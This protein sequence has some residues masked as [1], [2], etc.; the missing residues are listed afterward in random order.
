MN[1][2]TRDNR[3]EE[4]GRRTADSP[5]SGLDRRKPWQTGQLSIAVEELRSAVTRNQRITPSGR[6]GEQVGGPYRR[7]SRPLSSPFLAE[8]YLQ[9][10]PLSLSA[11]PNRSAQAERPRRICRR[12]HDKC[13]LENVPVSWES[14]PAGLSYPAISARPL[15]SSAAEAMERNPEER[16]WKRRRELQPGLLDHNASSGVHEVLSAHRRQSL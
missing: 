16:F 4:I 2:S 10:R 3:G 15:I 11:N 14:H 12:D 7:A 5:S 13:G 8:R 9:C 1:E 6:A